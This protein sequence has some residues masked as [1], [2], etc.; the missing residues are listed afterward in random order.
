MNKLKFAVVGDLVPG[1]SL[2]KNTLDPLSGISSEFSGCDFIWANLECSIPFE[3]TPIENRSSKVPGD[4]ETLLRI[5]G[6]RKFVF[7]MANNHAMDYDLKNLLNTK[8]LLN[9]ENIEVFGIGFSQEEARKPSFFEFSGIKIGLAAY[10]SDA[11]WVGDHLK[12]NCGEYVSI[13]ND[14][15]IEEVNR[16]SKLV[17]HLFVALH[18]GK[19]FVDY[20]IS[21]DR[22]IARTLIDNGAS[23]VFGHHPHVYQGYEIYKGKPIF[24]SMGNFL[25]PSFN[26]PQKLRW[27]LKERTGLAVK[28][29]ILDHESFDWEI[30][31]T[32]YDSKTGQVKIFSGRRKQKVLARVNRISI[33]LSLNKTEYKNKFEAHFKFIS[34]KLIVRGIIRN[35]FKPR[36]KHLIMFYKLTK[37]ILFGLPAKKST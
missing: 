33:P 19:E 17:D 35:I 22:E 13:L 2:I 18:F 5:I 23:A 28:I 36:S 4:Y 24:Y 10:S 7:S 31:P 14:K 16:Y 34:I 8:G 32:V 20:P 25:F 1:G 15:T 12:E 29:N 3:Y 30:N 37:Q 21:E 27:T 26:E 9:K 6:D 11:K